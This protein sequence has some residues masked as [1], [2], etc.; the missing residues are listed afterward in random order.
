MASKSK[1]TFVILDGHALLHRAWHALPPL[2][3]KDGL[4]IHGAYGFTMIM[5]GAIK[6]FRP[7]YMAVTFDLKGPTFRHEQYEQYKATREK[8]PDELYAQVDV[9]RS[10]LD[11]MEIP[12]F[13][14]PGFEAD[15][16]IGTLSLKAKEIGGIETIIVTGDLDTLQLVDAGTRVLTL[17]KGMSDT[18]IYDDKAV[19]E[20]FNLKPSQ[21]V[22]YKALRGDPSD[23][24]PGVKGIGEKTGSE[25][26]GEFGSI[27]KLYESIEKDDKR[28]KALKPAVREKLVAHKADAFAALD[29][30]RIRR[31][32]EFDFDLSKCVFVPPTREK[33]STVFTALEFMKLL[34]QFPEEAPKPVEKTATLFDAAPAAAPENA[35]REIKDVKA[36]SS[37]LASLAKYDSVAFRFVPQ[38]DDPVAPKAA[39]L[40]LADAKNAYVVSGSALRD[41]KP[42][43]AKFF[44]GKSQKICHDLKRELKVLATE[45]LPVD[46]PFFDLMI[47]SYLLH[48]GERRHALSA[49]LAYERGVPLEE[50]KLE[51]PE[52]RVARLPLELP[53][54]VPLALQFAGELKENKLTKLMD[55][56]ESP[57]SRVL[58]KM[59]TDGIAL[60]I[61]YFKKLQA[62]VG[63]ELKTL[64]KK[65]YKLAGEE[66]NINSPLQMKVVLFE[67]LGISPLGLKK[68][69][70]GGTLS[71]AASELEKLKD[72]HPIISEILRYRELS[73]LQS[74]YIEALPPLVYPAT[75]RI[76]AEFNQTV[77]ATG[78][79]SS[80]NPNLQNI[81]TSETEYGKR[82]RNG[83]VPA[84][85]SVLLAADYSQIE[86]RIAAH[87]AKEKVM[88]K[89]F[90]DGEDIHWRTAAVMWGEKEAPNRRRI[91]KVINFGLLYGMGPQS[92]AIA[93]DIS[94]GEAR[95]YI[96]QYFAAHPGIAAYM[97]AMKEK[98]AEDGYVETLF[99]RKRFFK[100]VKFMNPRERAEAE[101]QAIN[102]PIQGTQADMIK[103]AM[104]RLEGFIKEKYGDDA[105]SPVKML[106]QVHD[107]LV[108]EVRKDLVDEVAAGVAPI[109]EKVFPLSV[110]V[111]VNVSVGTRWGDMKKV[112]ET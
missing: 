81:P 65:I 71:T 30:C 3:T 90:K 35:A 66:F 83:F 57:L 43:L 85:G 97:A 13:T 63:A 25:L 54:L 109:M 11:A 91:A 24:I 56:I 7:D 12:V 78:R 80:A 5:L 93:A 8:K 104:V 48:A 6:Q 36:L 23:N 92:L 10:I 34:K 33:V 87:I 101:R 32:V 89:A 44:A 2:T 40:G 50:E 88:I 9:I 106:I 37:T 68:T 20:R 74:T 98:I 53:H 112:S 60:D 45:G 103:L 49:I 69:Q 99:G 64:V 77:A 21:L 31:D 111:A 62:E 107:E 95:D 102:M 27:A 29:L 86:L 52:T 55:D 108:F 59:E 79:L 51:R 96:A 110:P 82:V 39:A 100:N 58:A 75:G 19:K 84:K 15:D 17:R 67:K 105:K 26:I 42:L 72:A 22:D 46:G 61:P 14:A 16:V 76:H 4:V 28:A 47:A 73:K 18:V 41:G 38:S 1:K 94:F 70:K